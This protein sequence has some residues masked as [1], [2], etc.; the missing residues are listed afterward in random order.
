MRR[1]SIQLTII[2]VA[3]ATVACSGASARN[4]DGK[5][6]VGGATQSQIRQTPRDQLQDGGTF[7]WPIDSYPVN[8]NYHELDG[9][10]V[11]TAQID[12]AMLP[13]PFNI[14]ADGNPT[15]N[16]DLLAGEPKLTLGGL[17]QR[18]FTGY[19]VVALVVKSSGQACD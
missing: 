2:G 16:H 5:G 19:H 17:A 6:L 14:G 4:R 10:D 11:G 8:F 1:I 9:T 15:W 7:T 13:V 12:V 18:H 3:V